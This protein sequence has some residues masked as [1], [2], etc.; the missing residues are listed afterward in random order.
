MNNFLS[1]KNNINSELDLMRNQTVVI[2]NK[3]NEEVDSKGVLI[4]KNNE[5]ENTKLELQNRIEALD[6]RNTYLEDELKKN[7]NK[8]ILKSFVDL[9]DD[10]RKVL[11]ERDDYIYKYS[12]ESNKAKKYHQ[13][14][15]KYKRMINQ[16]D[17]LNKQTEILHK[18]FIREYIKLLKDSKYK[19]NNNMNNINLPDILEISKNILSDYKS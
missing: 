19:V 17:S 12:V 5:L 1:L 2:L 16:Y 4:Q 11:F 6:A 9:S 7:E 18:N 15:N 10:Y 13:L 3:L 14:M 8:D